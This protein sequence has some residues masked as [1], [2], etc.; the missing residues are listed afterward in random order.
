MSGGSAEADAEPGAAV[1]AGGARNRWQ[2]ALAA[3]AGACVALGVLV[4]LDVQD[5]SSGTAMAMAA[6]GSL[7]GGLLLGLGAI[8]F[9]WVRVGVDLDGV[10]VRCGAGG[11]PRARFRLADVAGASRA[12]VSTQAWGGWGYRIRRAG[13]ERAYVIRGGPALVLSLCDG[14]SVTVTVDDPDGAVAAIAAARAAAG[15]A[16]P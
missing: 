8:A 1:W 13:R 3:V 5:A 4:V 9:L 7:A 14:R 11:V 12:E 15:P 6:S 2:W 10:T 16:G